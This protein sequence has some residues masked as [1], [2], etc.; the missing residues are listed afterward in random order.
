MPAKPTVLVTRKLPDAVEARLQRD[1]M[2]RLNEADKLY[3]TQELLEK[4]QGADA[5]LI[6]GQDHLTAD[7]IAQLPNSVR[8]IATYS[9]GYEHIDLQAAS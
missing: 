5:L 8:A 4:S 9:V 3:T 6:T 2:A 7:A 1:Y